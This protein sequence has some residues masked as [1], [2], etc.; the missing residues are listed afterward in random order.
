[1]EGLTRGEVALLH[2]MLSKLTVA[3]EA[4]AARRRA[5]KAARADAAA[6]TVAAEAVE[7]E[8]EGNGGGVKLASDGR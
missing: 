2:G 1:M 3:S 6:A 4:T 8:V 7:V 5:A